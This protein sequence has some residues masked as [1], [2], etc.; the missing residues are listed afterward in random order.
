MARVT[1][2][3]A[4]EKMMDFIG[5]KIKDKLFGYN[6]SIRHH[7]NCT[8]PCFKVEATGIAK[9]TITFEYDPPVEVP[10]EGTMVRGWFEDGSDEF[11]GRSEG[12]FDGNDW[13][14]IARNKNYVSSRPVWEVLVP[15][16]KE[17]D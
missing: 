8:H 10:P 4:F 1:E 7:K 11:F 17:E 12:K 5:E 2:E 16:T 15:L 9:E 13:L 14:K 3:Q 6:F